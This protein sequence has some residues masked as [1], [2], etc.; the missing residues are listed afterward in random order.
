[1]RNLSSIE[2][3]P[4]VPASET[5]L[6][7]KELQFVFGVDRTTLWRRK[8]EGYPFLDCRIPSSVWMWCEAQRS[9]ARELGLSFR[10]FVARQWTDASTATDGCNHLQQSGG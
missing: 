8:R 10:E 6:S 3:P 2:C 4:S 1:M 9:A 5:L 7:Y